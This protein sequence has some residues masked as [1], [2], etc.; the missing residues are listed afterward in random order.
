MV[1]VW[2]VIIEAAHIPSILPLGGG[3]IYGF[4]NLDAGEGDT[5]SHSMLI[6]YSGMPILYWIPYPHLVI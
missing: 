5:D 4:I 6:A 2:Q 3:I 1:K